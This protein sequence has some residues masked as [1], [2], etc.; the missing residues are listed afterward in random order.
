MTPKYRPVFIILILIIFS[1]ASYLLGSRFISQIYLVKSKHLIKE[2]KYEKAIAFLKKAQ[3]YQPN[4]PLIYKS[5][6]YAYH[7]LGGEKP[8]K[9]AFG[10]VLNSKDAYLQAYKLVSIDVETVFGLALAERRLEELSLFFN[11]T[12]HSYNALPYYQELI[13]LGPNMVDPLKAFISYLYWKNRINL[14][15]ETVTHLVR[16]YPAAYG[17]LK[18]KPFWSPTLGFAAKKGIE[19]AIIEKI[20]PY[21]AHGVMLSILVEEKNWKGAIE[22]HKKKSFF[23]RKQHPK[24]YDASRDHFQLGR[25]YIKSGQ[26]EKALNNFIRAIGSSKSVDKTLENVYHTYKNKGHI[27]QLEQFHLRLKKIPSLAV[28]SEMLFVRTLIDLKKYD[29]AKKLL[30]KRDRQEPDSLSYFLFA[31]IAEKE[32]DL[33]AA[34]AAIHKA[35]RSEP[36]NSQYYAF[37]SRILDQQKRITEA[38]KKIDLAIQFS[39]NPQASL[40]H[41]RAMIRLKRNNYTGAVTDWKSAISIEPKNHRFLMYAADAL[42]QTGNISLAI[43]YIEKAVKLNPANETYRK[44]LK[45][46]KKTNRK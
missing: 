27:E 18:K 35:S 30:E 10:T 16:V 15:T 39:I 45:S 24:T 43:E 40:F 19:K 37:Y 2:N 5:M 3:R 21:N 31:K 6:G 28:K 29:Q 11:T 1:S 4:D 17:E 20:D 13:R 23:W 38:E 36:T 33:Y 46:A 32:N 22:Q 41:N 42:Q 9:E 8:L 7:L 25:L 44:K 12:Q 14:L 26:T 34:E